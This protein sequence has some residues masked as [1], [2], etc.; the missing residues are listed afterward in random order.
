MENIDLLRNLMIMAFADG[1]LSEPEL[2]FLQE[3]RRQWGVSIKDFN[4]ALEQAGTDNAKLELPEEHS[5]RCD[6]LSDFV[7]MMAADG[8]CA[9]LEMQLIAIA[10]VRLDVSDAELS[11]ILDDFLD[12]DDLVIDES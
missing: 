8:E 3:R 10:A 1:I 11:E 6:M 5:Q 7:A 4:L 2:E 12:D 9:E